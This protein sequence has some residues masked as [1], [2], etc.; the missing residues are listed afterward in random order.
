MKNCLSEIRKQANL[1]QETLAKELRVSRQTI[2]SLESGKYN[3]SIILAMRIA[4]RF[5]LAVEDIF[6]YEE[7][8]DDASK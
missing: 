6:I 5:D 4:R 7:E 2:S 3:P 1:S 8:I